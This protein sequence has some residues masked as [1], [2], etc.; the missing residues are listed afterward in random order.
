M[1]S[2]GAGYSRTTAARRILPPYRMNPNGIDPTGDYSGLA[3]WPEVEGAISMQM[4]LDFESTT[5]RLFTGLGT[6]LS[7]LD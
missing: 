2:R 4:A 1:I 7:S 3:V 5:I 6:I